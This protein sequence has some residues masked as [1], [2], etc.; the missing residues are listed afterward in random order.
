MVLHRRH[1]RSATDAGIFEWREVRSFG[2]PGVNLSPRVVPFYIGRYCEDAKHFEF[3]GMIDEVKIY[4]RVRSADEIRKEYESVI[5]R[6]Q[7]AK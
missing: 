7:A 4:H 5:A 1:L 2:A 6:K 3:R